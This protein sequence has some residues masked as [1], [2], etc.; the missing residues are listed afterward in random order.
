MRLSVHLSAGE[1]E[2]WG[3]AVSTIPFKP[4]CAERDRGWRGVPQGA[5]L[6]PSKKGEWPPGQ[7]PAP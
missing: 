4:L 3:W 6:D 5:Q 1:E 2:A 7:E